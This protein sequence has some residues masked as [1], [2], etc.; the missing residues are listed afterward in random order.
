VTS[1]RRDADPSDGDALEEFIP[2]ANGEMSPDAGSRGLLPIE[3]P[4]LR[5]EIAGLYIPYES[6]SLN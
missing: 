6:F 2:A 4:Y 1:R 5:Y 3:P